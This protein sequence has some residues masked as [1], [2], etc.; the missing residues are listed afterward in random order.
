MGVYLM[1]NL[2]YSHVFIL[3]SDHSGNESRAGVQIKAS[4]FLFLNHTTEIL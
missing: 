2:E 1:R 4:D 3:F